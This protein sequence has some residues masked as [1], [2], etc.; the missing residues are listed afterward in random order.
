MTE[1]AFGGPT[2]L[3]IEK[4]GDESAGVREAE[5]VHLQHGAVEK[6][7]S[8]ASGEPREYYCSHLCSGREQ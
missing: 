4:G 6:I 3:T 1:V 7:C 8:E 2:D 5:E